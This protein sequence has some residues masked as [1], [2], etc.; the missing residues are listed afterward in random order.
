MGY[1]IIVLA[2]GFFSLQNL[3]ARVLFNAYPLGGAMVGGFV[4]PTLPN[5]FLLLF[6][7]MLLG[8]PLMALVL[9]P[10]YP[11]LWPDLQRLQKPNH[12]R[13][14]GLAL[15]GG[16]LMF[17]YLGLLYVSIGLIPTGIALTLFF[18]FPVY[19]ALL[20]WGW[21][22]HRPT[23]MRW[24]IM[25]LILLGS[26]LTVPLG[27]EGSM[28]WL[29]V[30]LGLASA[31]AYALYTV[32]AQKAFETYHPLPFT[33]ISFAS[34]LVLSGLCLLIWPVN[35]QGLDWAGLWIGALL[36]A[37]ATAS[38]HLLNNL[39]I[40]WVGATAAAM[41]G[42]ANPALTAVLAALAL[43][44]HLSWVQSFGVVLV[45]LSVALLSLRQ[46]TS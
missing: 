38:G 28:S 5:S 9:T 39:G 10:L 22:G 27:G 29:G 1:L 34:T 19:T 6:M 4:E 16:G 33:G 31:L 21:F 35:L 8:V 37:L 17:L 45:T 32:V 46:S 43:Q 25:A 40:R 26:S 14:L 15:A 2:A 42:S 36:S 23:A 11:N 18:S 12:R 20:S 3:V 44:E 24:S 7:R 13:E 41:V 30:I